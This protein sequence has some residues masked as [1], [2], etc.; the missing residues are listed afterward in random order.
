MLLLKLLLL[1]SLRKVLS[2]YMR[3]IPILN[4]W[5]SDDSSFRSFQKESD[6]E[7]EANPS[8][9]NS[10]WRR[11]ILKFETLYLIPRGI[12][13]EVIKKLT[14]RPKRKPS[15]Y[16]QQNKLTVTSKHK[17]IHSDKAIKTLQ[18]KQKTLEEVSISN[19][20]K[21]LSGIRLHIKSYINLI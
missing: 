21:R 20:T 8:F 12:G 6:Q 13:E 18:K 11:K 10:R 2:F 16:F 1:S 3:K 19:E 17:R 14:Q 7:L 4:T 9:F 5:Q 15:S